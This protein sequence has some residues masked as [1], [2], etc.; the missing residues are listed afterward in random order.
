MSRLSGQRD[1]SVGSPVAGRGDPRLEGPDRPIRQHPGAARWVRGGST[2]AS[3]LK[4]QR[5]T[6]LE[7][8][9]H[10]DVPFERLV[11]ALEPERD[12]S[13]SPL[14]QVMLAMQDAAFAEVELPSLSLR[15]IPVERSGAR[16]D[17]TLF[18]DADGSEIGG[19]IEYSTELFD[20]VTVRRMADS[21]GRL[22]EQVAVDPEQPIADLRL[23]SAAQR[24][25]LEIEWNDT[26][27]S[28]GA[29]GLPAAARFAACA[30]E[31]PGALA[32]V[33][34]AGGCDVYL[35]YRQLAVRARQWASRLREAG[36]GPETVVAVCAEPSPEMI[37]GILAVLEAGGAYMPLEPEQPPAR[38]RYLLAD[39]GA[40]LALATARIRHRLPQVGLR[41][42]L[43]DSSPGES[44]VSTCR[45]CRT[46]RTSRPPTRCTP[47]G[48]RDGRR[49]WWSA[50][51]SWRASSTLAWPT[52]PAPVKC[53]LWF[54]SFAFDVS[55]LAFFRTLCEGGTLWLVPEESCRGS[56]G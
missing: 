12:L 26:D 50:R 14:F 37:I 52:I 4:R 39:T 9:A 20:R 22:L 40:E 34:P 25:Q 36:V 2:F 45:T 48:P 30:R 29:S 51:A 7:A 44:D 15:Q 53:F 41:V 10:Q 11:E 38:L 35:S 46:C 23:L 13:R 17:L 28:A 33:T 49:E 3:F 54:G 43:L 16:F 19:E 42:L 56:E 21:L 27:T 31:T 5:D 32:L 55:L 24:Q 8:Q 6:V 1:V 47:R 18:I